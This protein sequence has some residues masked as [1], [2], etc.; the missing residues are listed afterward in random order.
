MLDLVSLGS[1][2]A[3]KRKER[4]L[5]QRDFAQ[6]AAVSRATLDALDITSVS[7]RLTPNCLVMRQGTL[8]ERDAIASL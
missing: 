8:K 4:G 5:S 6:K 7:V 3:A 1:R 2:I